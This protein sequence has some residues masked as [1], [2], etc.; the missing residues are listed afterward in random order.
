MTFISWV[1]FLAYPNLFGTQDYVVIV[2][3]AKC[4]KLSI[5]CYF[6]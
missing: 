3:G 4:F 6:T 5:V 2:V 1:L